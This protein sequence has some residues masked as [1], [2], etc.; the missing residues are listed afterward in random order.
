MTA[1]PSG[2]PILLNAS[3]SGPES[4][5]KRSKDL[6]I[7]AGVNMTRMRAGASRVF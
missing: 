3:G 5:A 2:P 7:P 6:S 4:A 1:I